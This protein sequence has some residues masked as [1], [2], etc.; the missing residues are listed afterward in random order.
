MSCKTS[1]LCRLIITQCAEIFLVFMSRLD[2]MVHSFPAGV[3]SVTLVTLVFYIFMDWLFMLYKMIL[4]CSLIFTQCA[5]ISLVFMSRLDVSVQTSLSG[6]FSATMTTLVLG[7]IMSTN[8]MSSQIGLLGKFFSTIIAF[9]PFSKMLWLIVIKITL[10]WL[11]A[12]IAKFTG[13]C[14]HY[15]QLDTNYSLPEGNEILRT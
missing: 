8:N 7:I 14:H 3:F 13:H 2:V 15:D 6:V 10:P 11:K 1:L 12:C 4:P 9:K 5:G